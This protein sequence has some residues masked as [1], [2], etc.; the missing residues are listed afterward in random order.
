MIVHGDTWFDVEAAMRCT[1]PQVVRADFSSRSW[2]VISVRVAYTPPLH[3]APIKD[4]ARRIH[5]LYI[6]GRHGNLPF[7][8]IP[9]LHQHEDIPP[10]H[11]WHGL[12]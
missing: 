2:R 4:A 1:R 6:I 5:A 8:L 7:K 3:H 12:R 9:I 10:D 11:D